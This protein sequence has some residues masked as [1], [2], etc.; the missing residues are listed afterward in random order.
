MYNLQFKLVHQGKLK[1]WIY[2]N[3][4]NSLLLH[5]FHNFITIVCLCKENQYE[6]SILG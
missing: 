3:Y 6:H 5:Y 1:A 2:H 4:E